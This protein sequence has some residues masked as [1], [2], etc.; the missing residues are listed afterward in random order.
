VADKESKRDV[1]L[2]SAES[3]LYLSSFLLEMSRFKLLNAYLTLKKKEDK[4]LKFIC[5]IIMLENSGFLDI[6]SVSKI[7]LFLWGS[8]FGDFL[9]N[10]GLI[11]E[12]LQF[13]KVR[14][15]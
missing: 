13:F 7:T 3:D 1:T 2:L 9:I 11:W 10:I 5:E 12:S 15:W 8:G 6:I 14:S 4:R